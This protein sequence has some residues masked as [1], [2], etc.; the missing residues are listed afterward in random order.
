MKPSQQARLA[1]I[2]AAELRALVIYEPATG[3]FRWLLNRRGHA[4][5]G[6]PAGTLA[7][8]GY[9]HIKTG[10]RV[11]GAHRLAWLYM[12]GSFP[13]AEIDHKDRV[14]SNNAWLNLRAATRSQNRVNRKAPARSLP[15]GVSITLSGKYCARVGHK[16]GYL[17]SFETAEAA[18][19]AYRNAATAA[20]GPF[21]PGD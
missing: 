20:Y 16:D 7:H 10:G 9:I 11:Y 19:V 8:N 17:G 21:L 3:L 15:R 14:R 1:D 5:A 18:S 2:T 12:T 4:R 6:D 13:P